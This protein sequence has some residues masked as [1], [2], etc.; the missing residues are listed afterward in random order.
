M[1]LF[2]LLL[3]LTTAGRAQ[4]PLFFRQFTERDGLSS[5]RTTC[6]LRDRQGF[7]WVGT[8]YGLNR[9]DGRSFRHFLP[10]ASQADRTVSNEF[11]S[12]MAQDSAGFLWIATRK[13]LNRYD[14][15]NGRFQTWQSTGRDDGSLPNSLINSLLLDSD[16]TLWLACDNRDLTR[17]DTRT[18]TFATFPWKKTA[19]RVL[20]QKAKQ[21]YKTI[22]SIHQK[23]G[24]ELLL[25]TNMGC[26]VF[27]KKRQTFDFFPLDSTNL[28]KATPSTACPERMYLP[29]WDL[30]VLRLDPCTG[31]WARAFLPIEKSA[32]G[33]Q[34]HVFAVEKN[35]DKYWVMAEKGL[36]IIDPRTE[37]LEA[38]V[39]SP[40]NN[41][42]AP[43]GSLSSF[44]K[45][46]DG[47]VWLGGERGFWQIAPS[48]QQFGFV[49]LLP[50]NTPSIYNRFSRFLDAADGGRRFI[51][52]FYEGRLWVME[53]GK[54]LKIMDLQGLAGILHRD[55]RGGV[56]VSGGKKIFRLDEKTLALSPFPVPENMLDASLTSFFCDMAEDAAGNLWFGN[57]KEGL[58]IFNPA[59][60]T[61]RKPGEAE[62]FISQ[63]PSCLLADPARKTVWIGT[64]DYGLFRFD[65]PS[66]QF[67]LYRP[68]EAAPESSLGAYIVFGLCRD[69][70]GKI[71][72]ATDP[73]GVSRFDYDAPP[74]QA[75]T[76]LNTQN[77]LPSNQATSVLSDQNG[78]VWVG[79]TKGLA[80]VDARS[81]RLRSWSRHSGLRNEAIDLPLN[82]GAAGEV[83]IGG[84][85]GY[86]SFFPDSLL[87]EAHDPR[88]LLTSFK[89]FDQERL[90]TLNLNDLQ[91]TS[92]TWEENFFTFDFA[93]ANFSRPEK[94]EYAARLIG[95]D[96]DW[97]MLGSRRSVSYTNVPPGA[98]ILE[99]K[100]GREGLWNEP[101]L[102]LEIEI[103]PPFWATW[104]FRALMFLTLAG[105]VFGAYKYRIA[106]I[107]REESL[108]TAFQKRI[109]EVEMT[110]LRAQ[111]NP[112]F[113]F[114]CLNS[115]NRF[116][117]VNEPES[118]SVYLTKFSRL[119]RL[120]LDNSRSEK[121]PLDRELDALRLYIEMEAMRFADRFAH[122]IW[123]SPDLQPEHIEVP[124]LLIQ[125]FVENAIWHGLMHKKAP[126]KLSVRVFAEGQTLCFE[127]EDDGIGRAKA[128][129]LR[130]KS[131]QAHK[132]HGMSV[133][134]ER[135]Q[136][137]NQLY[138]S[139]ASVEVE[140]L[141]NADGSAAG[142]RVRVRLG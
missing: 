141:A 100:T 38:V 42:S 32:T 50:E 56:W 5:P 76:T 20:P 10:D 103:L 55:R 133:T 57:N 1:R 75:F 16:N 41:Y 102:R 78:N 93:S 4:Q 109:A 86:E 7:L 71:W 73:G 26:F 6:I 126:G 92:L 85:T 136:V 66:G 98:Y 91:R 82:P 125:P 138:G 111:M 39:P 89:V 68:D 9:Y 63:S 114:N 46:P 51:T 29:S 35:G 43:M 107:R 70:Q 47:T 84:K 52:D 118:A 8:E 44:Y 22:Y 79:T 25:N 14:P 19:E 15:S 74:G 17:M 67:K 127:I 11:I 88:V 104:W 87:A 113:V 95:F 120:I 122:E 62:G 23:S 72:A 123:V 60:Q 28:P 36:F 80:W 97:Q 49:P 99:V 83:I 121:V 105:A 21:A 3:F 53:R 142:T 119:I 61:W 131:A 18:G 58:L 106:Q 90:N 13:G 139:N 33:G 69:G 116:I 45:E 137:I 96:R 30:D 40:Q 115:I 27:H 77:G 132:S 117:L 48:A 124:P 64:E 12:A 34:R 65:E 112:H 140:D 37:Q 94:N 59:T 108:K 101:G 54:C 128:R 24:D 2:A 134:A 31:Q 135:I 129:A 110:A 81:L 130:S